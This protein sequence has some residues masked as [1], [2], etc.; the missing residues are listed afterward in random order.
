M[1]MRNSFSTL[2]AV[3]VLALSAPLHAQ[4]R[5]TVSSVEL[6]AAAAATAEPRAEAV[7]QLLASEQVQEAAS[8]MGLD[9]TEISARVAALDDATL[10]LLAQQSG[11]DEQELVGAGTE[12]IVISSTA[13]IIILLLL[14]LVLR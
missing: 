3:A 4:Q 9:A 8:R 14:I 2:A 5:S 6:D 7:R 11:L 1:S 12:R 10:E 13:L